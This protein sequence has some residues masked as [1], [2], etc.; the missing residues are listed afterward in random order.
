[1]NFILRL[2]TWWRF[3][4]LG[5]TLYTW[6]KGRL[7]GTDAFGN[8]YYQSKDGKRRWA[9]YAGEQEASKVPPDW[10]GWLHYTWDK[11]PT[12]APLPHKPWEKP[13][14]PNLTG[15][16]MAYAPPGS[17]RRGVVDA[18]RDYEAWQPE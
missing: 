9:I 13:H 16:P 5:T 2:L 8:R 10:H 15:T 11:P 3:E 1:M 14:Q 18:P 17:L 12:E 4:T 6:R 7:V